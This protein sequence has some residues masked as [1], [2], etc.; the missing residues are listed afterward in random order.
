LEW[1]GGPS[2]ETAAPLLEAAIVLGRP[3]GARDAASFILRDEISAASSIKT[4]A[5]ALVSQDEQLSLPFH[6]P[7]REA[8]RKLKTRLRE[9]PRDAL[10]W[11]DIARHY[12]TIGQN[13]RAM[14]A[15]DI[16]LKLAPNNRFVV[17]SAVRLNVHR[18]HPDQAH[19]LLLKTRATAT[20][21]W[22]M[23][24]EIATASLAE[25]APQFV[26]QARSVLD[27]GNFPARD[28]A[29]LAGAIA[30]LD[31]ESG[32]GIRAKKLF[33]QSLID[34][35]ENVVAQA[36]WASRHHHAVTL[37]PALIARIPRTFE[38][39]A[40]AAFEAGAW[41]K[42]LEEAWL[43]AQDEPFSKLPASHGSFVAVTIG[44]YEQGEAFARQGLQPNPHDATLLNNLVV[45]LAYQGR[46]AEAR[47][48]FLKI[49]RSSENEIVLDAT[50]GLIFSR[51]GK[52]DL[53]RD[54]YAAAMEKAIAKGER[55]LWA[56]AAFHWMRE[57]LYRNPSL[58]PEVEK[59]LSNITKRV[60]TPETRAYLQAVKRFSEA[61][62]AVDKAV[63]MLETFDKRNFTTDDL[64]RL[65]SL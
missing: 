45:A 16:A 33:R 8:L 43:W 12:S 64:S 24:A 59:Q 36:N 62:E 4:L 53:A 2:I 54:A 10:L 23:S 44:E 52:I 38:A 65:P 32:K 39:A 5:Q 1:V 31:L 51:E 49:P 20:D 34:P 35:N 42:A 6:E 15:L 29:E 50:E 22:L 11:V 58:V 13:D 17:R 27:D 40:W 26:R 48:A 25:K 19:H 63:K 60:A 21:P 61:K 28:L 14:R 56:R 47:K 37:D 18:D 55:Q 3:E 7:P 57:I 9:D 30:T 41:T 46:T